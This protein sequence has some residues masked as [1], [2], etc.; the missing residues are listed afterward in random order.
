MTSTSSYTT[1]VHPA[2]APRPGKHLKASDRPLKS[3]LTL[4]IS[5]PLYR[6]DDAGHGALSRATGIE[7]P[8]ISKSKIVKTSEDDELVWLGRDPHTPPISVNPSPTR[9]L[10]SPI[11][12][13]QG[14]EPLAKGP[15]ADSPY[16]SPTSLIYYHHQPSCSTIA[17]ISKS[18][19]ASRS[20]PD[21]SVCSAYDANV[22]YADRATGKRPFHLVNLGRDISLKIDPD[23]AERA[24]DHHRLP[25][26]ISAEEERSPVGVKMR[27]RIENWSTPHHRSTMGAESPASPG[28]DQMLTPTLIDPYPQTPRVP[29]IKDPSAHPFLHSPND[30]ACHH[31]DAGTSD[32]RALDF[33]PGGLHDLSVEVDKGTFGEKDSL[34]ELVERTGRVAK[35]LRTRSL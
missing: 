29:L 6:S 32:A 24:T 30:W 3:A 16:N 10:A 11:E 21:T 8:H 27:D 28:D 2:T 35:I 7:D 26:H 14:V 4:A 33:E 23:L 1:T 5:P 20:R 31:V 22:M 18:S 34:Q 12:L 15:R 9:P 19:I 25:V 17:S 13:A